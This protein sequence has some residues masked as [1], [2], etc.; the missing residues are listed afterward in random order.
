[1]G[2]AVHVP[3]QRREGGDDRD[4]FIVRHHRCEHA[5][6]RSIETGDPDIDAVLF[7]AG[8]A[9]FEMPSGVAFEVKSAGACGACGAMLRIWCT[10]QAPVVFA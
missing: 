10:W 8:L 4:I 3:L 6:R 5:K 2:R 1:M 7:P 9:G